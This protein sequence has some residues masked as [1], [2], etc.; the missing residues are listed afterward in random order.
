MRIKQ[1]LSGFL[2]FMLVTTHVFGQ[3]NLT[4]TPQ[5][6][7]PEGRLVHITSPLLDS[8]ESYELFLKY[9]DSENWSSIKDIS[10]SKIEEN[11]VKATWK[12]NNDTPAQF[13]I[14]AYS[15]EGDVLGESISELV[16]TKAKWFN[17][18]RTNTLI[19]LILISALI[20]YYIERAKKAK[21]IYLRPIAGLKAFEEAVGRAQNRRIQILL[22][23]LGA[24]STA[25]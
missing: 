13:K 19:A 7:E 25:E 24:T 4:V 11:A 21:E 5:T 15:S 18:H 1:I 22:V 14:A 16:V 8:A 12:I 3:L 10:A 20:L 17:H 6:D 9:E 23:P 2:M